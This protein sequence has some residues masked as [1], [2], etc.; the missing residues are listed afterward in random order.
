[1]SNASFKRML[2]EGVH[3]WM[4]FVAG[5]L[6]AVGLGHACPNG[7]RDGIEGVVGWFL[8]QAPWVH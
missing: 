3:D 2:I 5:A 1:M 7:V 4:V 8:R 6:G